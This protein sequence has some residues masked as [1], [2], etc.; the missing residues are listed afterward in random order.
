MIFLQRGSPKMA[1]LC[2]HWR[3]RRH[4]SYRVISCRHRRCGARGEDDPGPTRR[5]LVAFTLI[6]ALRSPASQ[7]AERWCRSGRNN[8]DG[9]FP[10]RHL[11]TD[12]QVPVHRLGSQSKAS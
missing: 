3:P 6:L 1:H 7:R 12:L 5:P 9:G 2:R 11:P 10:H 8:I 4:G